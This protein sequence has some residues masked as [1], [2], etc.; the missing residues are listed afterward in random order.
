MEHDNLRQ[1]LGWYL[2]R[3]E[4]EAGMRLAGALYRFWLYNDNPSEGVWWL[5]A[6]LSRGNG[7]PDSV[8][9][10]ALLGLGSLSGQTL[11]QNRSGITALRQ[12][13]EIYRSLSDQT[14]RLD[15]ATA[16]NNLGADLVTIGD[17]DGAEACYQEALEISKALD[18]QWGVALTLG[19]LGRVAASKGDLEEA[20]VR[21]DQGIDEARKVGSPRLL[22]DA[23][24]AKANFEL[25][26]GTPEKAV[27]AYDES[28]RC[29][30]G[31]SHSA[32]VQWA[33]AD[34]AVARARLGEVGPA[35]E[36]FTTNAAAFLAAE[37]TGTQG[38]PLVDLAL[39]RAEFDLALGASERAGH[40]L[41]FVG[42]LM[43][44][45]G[46]VQF[47]SKYERLKAEVRK[48]L[49]PEQ[50]AAA[51]AVGRTMNAEVIVQLIVE[52]QEP[53]L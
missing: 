9:A 48:R 51:L 41:G 3:G 29:Y 8:R 39:G 35:F 4:F 31:A 6:F 19:N 34:M 23:F 1:A 22:G 20:R 27:V 14:T 2:D 10:K 17:T 15:Y 16:L 13:V 11:G 33:T 40:L 38:D 18:V 7:V 50:F 32:S 44:V 12:S 25:D 24:W 46:Y 5:E 47:V 21:F 52:T 26:F 28:I 49:D 53:T 36:L 45:E 37:E 42:G 30:S 43:E